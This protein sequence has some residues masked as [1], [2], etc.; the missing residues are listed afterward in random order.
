MS[1]RT[2]GRI[3]TLFVLVMIAI[4][5]ILDQS[6][7]VAAT[8]PNSLA[9]GGFRGNPAHTAPLFVAPLGSHD[10]RRASPAMRHGTRTGPR[11]SHL[12]GTS[13]H[14]HRPKGGGFRE[15]S[16]PPCGA[17]WACGDIG[18][19]PTVGSDSYSS[20]TWTLS[21]SGDLGASSDAFHYVWQPLQ[22][23][24]A[25]TVTA[26][27]ATLAGTGTDIRAGVMLRDTTDP[28]GRFYAVMVDQ[29]GAVTVQFRNIAGSLDSAPIGAT[30]AQYLQIQRTGFTFT[31]L[32][33]TTG[34]SGSY[35]P[36][37]GS[38]IGLDMSMMEAG[39]FVVSGNTTLTTATFDG[40][41]TTG[42]G[43]AVV[44]CPGPWSCADVGSPA[45]QGSQHAT[46]DASSWVLDGAGYGFIYNSGG[47][48]TDGFHFV[49]QQFPSSG[50]ISAR[51]NYNRGEDSGSEQESGLMFRDGTG[52]ATQYF[53]IL[54]RAGKGVV[55]QHRDCGFGTGCS[56]GFPTTC[57][58]GTAPPVY[59]KVTWSGGTVFAGFT[60][61]DGQNWTQISCPIGETL[62]PFTGPVV[63]GLVTSGT[64]A[65]GVGTFDLL[66]VHGALGASSSEVNSPSEKGT[67]C[68]TVNPV[69]CAT[70]AFWHTFD[71]I[72]IPGRGLPLDFTH[73]YD[74]LN[75]AQDSPLG[76]GWTDSY[77]LFLSTDATGTITVHEENGSSVPFDLTGTAYQPP[78]RVEATLVQ[79]QDGTF[80]FTRLH[81]QDQY[82]FSA[83][84]QSSSGQ[85]Q[86]E[87]DRNGY[88]TTLAYTSG[89]LSTITDPAGRAL[90]LL[91]NTGNR[92]ASVKDLMNR[93]VSYS[94]D[95]SGN[96]ISV[97]D[98]GGFTS[99]FTYD[100]NHLLLTM[101]DGRG[102]VVKNTYDSQNRV[103]T[104]IVDPT[105]SNPQGLNR[106]TTFGYALNADGSHETTI[107]DPK[108]NVTLQQYQNNEILALT[109][110]NGTPQQATW[111]Y[112]YDPTSLGMTNGTDPNGNAWT[113]TYD[114]SGNLL[115][116]HDPLSHQTVYTYDT[117][118]D[119]TSVTD[120][121]GVTTTLTYDAV[122]NLL[123]AS[124]PLVGTAQTATVTLTYGDSTHPGDV[125]KVTDP[126]G[127]STVLSYAS[128]GDL[129]RVLDPVGN[130]TTYSYD[131]VGRMT[132]TVAPNGNVSGG[133][134]SLYTTTLATNGFGDIT[135]VTDPLGH[136]T[137]YGYDADRNT[138]SVTDALTN[139]TTSTYDRANE[140]TLV[141]K[142]DGTTQTST[143][144]A[145]GN[146]TV[147]K[148]GL[149]QPT[150]S[151][152]D[153]LNRLISVKDPL[154]RTTRYAYDKGGR[155]AILTDA[156]GHQITYGEDGANEL[157]RITY[158]DGVTPNV[159]YSYDSDGQRTGMTDG[160]GTSSY[161]YDSLHRLTQSTDGS[162]A[163]V[164]YAYDLDGNLTGLTYPDNTLISRG[165]D[166]DSR[167]VSLSSWSGT[168]TTHFG[169]DANSNLTSETYPTTTSTTASFSYNT[170]DQ[171]TQI[172][173]AR[174]GSPVW[175]FGYG[176]DSNGQL[177]SATDPLD[178]LQHSYGYDHLNRLTS[179]N[180]T[181]ASTA[182]SFDAAGQLKTITDSTSSTFGYDVANELTSLTRTSGGTTIA[183]WALSY[184]ANGDRSG[185]TDSV[186][187]QSMGY[188]YDQEDRLTSF[189][190]GGSTVATYA[191]NGDGLR[192]SKTV[193]GTTTHQVWDL[194]EGM[195]LLIQDGS[196]KY[197][198]GPGGLPVEQQNGSQQV[199]YEQDQ[200]G[201]TRG[202]LDSTGT[203]LAS[204]TYGPFG[205]LRSSMGTTTTPFGYAG[206]YTD[207][208]S[209]LQYLRARYYDPSM[210]Q[211]LTK[212]P[213]SSSTQTPYAY[214]GNTPVNAA[215]PTGLRLAVAGG[216]CSC[217]RSNPDSEPW[218]FANAGAISGYLGIGTLALGAV[219]AVGIASPEIFA[220]LTVGAI[221]L[222]IASLAFGLI[223]VADDIYHRNVLATAVDSAGIVIGFKG[224]AW[225]LRAVK[226]AIEARAS[227]VQGIHAMLNGDPLLGAWNWARS[228]FELDDSAVANKASF[229]LGISGAGLAGASAESGLLLSSSAGYSC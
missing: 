78:S 89:R 205:E 156:I 26:H 9:F 180:R 35:T 203:T 182:W 127:W 149:G 38:T 166:R 229:R 36:L 224:L 25:G 223:G 124:R 100:A 204:F 219:A 142:A 120:P 181:G 51:V 115:T 81:G 84:T 106:V 33:S 104:Q 103:I 122:G 173:D 220:A 167:L 162:G 34:A 119:A 136:Q 214:A 187:G 14:H 196:T 98:L 117:L 177:S 70:G 59:V 77:N 147:Q 1:A 130:V 135:A 8:S 90:T 210:A 132:S 157:K 74:S 125:S 133:T 222:S 79:N 126:N 11:A 56:L 15:F 47:G 215:D 141:T 190:T 211:F 165:Y 37:A 154:N 50:S 66:Q 192:M 143:Y 183:N 22:N 185:Q 46:A 55:V 139:V 45:L 94:Y 6:P 87:V 32:T 209:G 217:R 176:R 213:L 39:L 49:S 112:T 13:R 150:T 131:P 218:V 151:A 4:S 118:N 93:Q 16:T 30:T 206:Q 169:Y 82:V 41:T 3:L 108:G 226:Y 158:N 144:D 43:N 5:G 212:D 155:L 42:G 92:I 75:A 101:Q 27:I 198:T 23:V 160:T 21:G 73:T 69:N 12:T 178:S 188:G 88:T 140:L 61:S 221:A 76:F 28:S 208:E 110:G 123:I 172:Q 86:K 107:T 227:F 194:A 96:L 163:V 228:T 19:P 171:L 10:H 40:A 85:L 102:T 184:N 99:A 193:S 72:S 17:T 168:A 52:A 153:P 175:T 95:A 121:N 58:D 152:F 145:D 7:A 31:A 146:R 191:Y 134:P 116:H 174:A 54:V 128:H 67:T 201:S 179:D 199:Y 195:P 2:H 148:D 68:N 170:A 109:A 159:T 225:G 83:P 137:L 71:A 207:A 63:G 216:G 20:G 129:T 48:G 202:L 29:H 60:S 64:N 164:K 105:S 200:L 161:V 97:T 57:V 44:D 24:S 62:H 113:S 80:T 18:T 111:T 65:M 53:G 189:S 186:S 138:T 197:A 114:A 91:Y